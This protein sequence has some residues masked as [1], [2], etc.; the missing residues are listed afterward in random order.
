MVD[1][2]NRHNRHVDDVPGMAEEYRH[3]E[4]NRQAETRNPN[5]LGL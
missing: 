2:I 3:T 1:K 5:G 4:G